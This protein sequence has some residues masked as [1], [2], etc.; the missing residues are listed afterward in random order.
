VDRE[1]NGKRQSSIAG[2]LEH[3]SYEQPNSCS[4]ARNAEQPMEMGSGDGAVL[5]PA[6][7][8]SFTKTQ[9]PRVHISPEEDHQLESRMR[10]IR[11]SGSEG[12]GDLRVSPYP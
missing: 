11:Q 7:Q 10:E 6:R 8:T 5:L 9:V 3:E 2:R 4:Y 1:Q 12:G